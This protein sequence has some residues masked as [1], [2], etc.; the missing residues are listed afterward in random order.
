MRPLKTREQL[1]AEGRPD[2][3]YEKDGKVW[4]QLFLTRVGMETSVLEL[5]RSGYSVTIIQQ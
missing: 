1:I 2:I 4:T 5:T 3:K